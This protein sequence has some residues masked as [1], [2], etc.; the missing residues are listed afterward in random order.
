MKRLTVLSIL[1]AALALA[2]CSTPSANAPVDGT[3]HAL[4][5][6]TVAYGDLGP[7]SSGRGVFYFGAGDAL[8]EEVF[9]CYVAYIRSDEYY[10]TGESG[11]G[12]SN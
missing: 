1:G 4:C 12:D 10:A 5:A 6:D 7:V 9:A 2:G 11:F 8:G 3:A